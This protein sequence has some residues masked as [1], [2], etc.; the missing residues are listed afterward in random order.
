[1][2]FKPSTDLEALAHQLCG[3]APL[4]K[5]PIAC[6]APHSDGVPCATCEWDGSLYSVRD[7][8]LH[9][10]TCANC[11]REFDGAAEA[12]A[13]SVVT[14]ADHE[15]AASFECDSCAGES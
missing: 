3:I 13:R 8:Y 15:T 11:G 14:H 9:S 2:P 6:P 4:P 12:P 7:E 10:W 1:M 5:L